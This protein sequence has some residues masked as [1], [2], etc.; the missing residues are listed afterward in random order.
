VVIVIASNA[1]RSALIGQL[2]WF[3]ALIPAMVLG[4]LW[5]GLLGGAI[6]NVVV[7]TLIVLPLTMLQMRSASRVVLRPLLT[8]MLFPL[9]AAVVAGVAAH[10]VSFWSA[11]S[12][13][14]LFAG[15]IVGT[16][17]YAAILFRWG[18]RVLAE[19]RVLYSRNDPPA[20]SEVDDADE[21]A[22][23][24]L[25]AEGREIDRVSDKTRA[26]DEVTGL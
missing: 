21:A 18:R 15:G 13:G 5:G 25:A 19:T 16:I 14:D 6:A 1:P 8:G 24:D 3:F 7:V 23:G 2:V 4:V 22:S 26:I 11:S 10:L 12:W 20:G 9:L 17:I